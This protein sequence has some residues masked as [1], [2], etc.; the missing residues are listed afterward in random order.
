LD[1]SNEPVENFGWDRYHSQE[2]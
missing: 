1:F 2:N